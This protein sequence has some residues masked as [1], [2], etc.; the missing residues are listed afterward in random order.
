MTFNRKLLIA[1][2][3]C[4]VVSVCAPAASAASSPMHARHAMV[5]SVNGFASAAGIEVLKRGGNAVDAAV[6]VGFALAVVHPQAGNIGGGGFM[7]L[8]LANGSTHFLDYRE[9]APAAATRDMYLDSSGEVIKNASTV[10]YK[11][12]AVPSSLAGLVNAKTRWG[13]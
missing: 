13:R 9:K 11:A 10:G 12:I 7:L 3:L 6:A 8:R 5:V 1:L 2:L 4:A